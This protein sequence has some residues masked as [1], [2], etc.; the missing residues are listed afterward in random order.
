M[1]KSRPPLP[2]DHHPE[3]TTTTSRP[4]PRADHK[5]LRDVNLLTSTRDLHHHHEKIFKISSES[6]F[7]AGICLAAAGICLAVAGNCLDARNLLNR[8]EPA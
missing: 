4:S 3:P 6:V 2:A 1:H 7:A 5:R 8:Q